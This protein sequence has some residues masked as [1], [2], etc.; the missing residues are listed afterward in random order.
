MNF[1]LL[2]SRKPG[3]LQKNLKA[4]GKDPGLEVL[5]LPTQ[6]HDHRTGGPYTIMFDPTF[7]CS[8]MGCESLRLNGSHSP[9]TTFNYLLC[10]FHLI[11]RSDVRPLLHFL[12]KSRTRLVGSNW[13]PSILC[14]QL[15][16]WCFGQVCP[17]SPRDTSLEQVAIGRYIMKGQCHV[18]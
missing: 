3:D 17:A 10:G 6:S 18:E 2:K 12:G 1:F 9:S 16:N 11:C 7:G 5:G 13:P 15:A 14:C 8:A 4:S